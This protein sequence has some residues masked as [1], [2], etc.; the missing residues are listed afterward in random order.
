MIDVILNNET[1]M[2]FRSGHTQEKEKWEKYPII[3]LKHNSGS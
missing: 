1:L 3:N 2:I